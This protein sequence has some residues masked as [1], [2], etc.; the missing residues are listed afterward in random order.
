MNIP[1]PRF[2]LDESS[3]AGQQPIGT[4]FSLSNVRP[5]DISKEKIRGGQRPG[6]TLAYNTQISGAAHPVLLMTS[7]VTTFIAPES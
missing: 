1:F 5:F 4:S 3:P 2:G 7:I 6:T